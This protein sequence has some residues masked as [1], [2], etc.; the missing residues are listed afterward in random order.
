M[1]NSLLAGNHNKTGILF[2]I[3]VIRAS[4]GAQ[5]KIL[6]KHQVFNE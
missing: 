4:P 2:N 5:L 3:S 1:D 6:T